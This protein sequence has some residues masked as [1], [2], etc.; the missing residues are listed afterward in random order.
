MAGSMP[1][2]GETITLAVVANDW[3]HTEDASIFL[4]FCRGCEE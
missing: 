4:R 3:A 2:P 1:L